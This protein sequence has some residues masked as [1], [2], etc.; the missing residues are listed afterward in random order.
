M[1]HF[2]KLRIYWDLLENEGLHHSRPWCHQFFTTDRTDGTVPDNR[3]V[4]AGAARDEFVALL[5]RHFTEDELELYSAENLHELR[6]RSKADV[7]LLKQRLIDLLTPLGVQFFD[8]T[9]TDED[10]E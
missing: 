8:D 2:P 7:L 6:A 9:D 4:P 3:D 10:D 1:A 5:R